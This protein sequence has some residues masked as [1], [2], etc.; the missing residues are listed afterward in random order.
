VTLLGA[1]ESMGND[2]PWTVPENL[3]RLN[4]VLTATGGTSAQGWQ[5]SL[6]GYDAKW[7]ATDQVPQRLIDAGRYLGKPFGRFDSLDPSDG[8]ST[9]RYSL[10]G[11]WHRADDLGSSRVSAYAMRYTLALN[12]NFTYALERPETGDQFAQR[13]RRTVAGLNAVQTINHQWLGRSV[14]SEVGLQ[15]RRDDISVGLFDTN[16]RQVVGVT[17]DDSVGR[18]CSGSMARA[19]SNSRPGSV[20]WWAPELIAWTCRCKAIPLRPT[21]GHLGTSRFHPSFP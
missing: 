15:V 6:M 5:A 14:R 2:G 12:S 9:S 17:R 19:R 3:K 7:I 13:D 20:P 4:A 21:P 11:Q 1:L 16:Q 8:G 10:S 18:P